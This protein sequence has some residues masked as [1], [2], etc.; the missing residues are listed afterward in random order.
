MQTVGIKDLKNNL[1]AYVRAAEAGETV[2]VTDRGKVVAQL[3]PAQ[4]YP[5]PTTDEERMAQLVREGHVTPAKGRWKGPPKGMA[6]MSF[7]EIMRGLDADRED[8]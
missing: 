5:E 2:L 6:L 1:S 3:M 8:R 4:A 7:E